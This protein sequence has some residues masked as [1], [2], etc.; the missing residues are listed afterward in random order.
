MAVRFILGRSG[1]GK[2]RWCFD[3]IV[4]SLRKSPLG[5]PILWILPRQ[6]TF[7]A[8]RWLACAGGLG[9]YFRV[10]AISFEDLG[11]E[12]LAEC[13]GAAAQ[14]VSDLGRRMILGHLLRRLQGQ[15][16]FFQQSAHQP[17]VA[18]ELD[19]T[20]DEL[21]RGGFDPD[22]IL[23]QVNSP[24]NSA[25]GAKLADLS[26]IWEAYGKFLGQDRLD[27]SRRLSE[28][29]LAIERC[30][31]LRGADVF[32]DSFYDFTAYERQVLAALGKTC[33]SVA[34]ALTLDPQSQCIGNPHLNPED[35]S[36]FYRG[37]Q[38]YRR[39][40]F[41]FKEEQVLID[42]PLM[43][44][45]Q[46]RFAQ[47]AVA[48]L[49]K[50]D[51]S[52]SPASVAAIRLIE[53]ADRAGEV[54]AAARAIADLIA[55]GLR[56]RDIAVLMRRDDD[57]RD[58]IDA[59]FRE[60]G[61][62]YFVDRRRT[63]A[64][65]PL[66]RLIRAAVLIARDNW[67]HDAVMAAIKTSLC[68]LKPLEADELENYVLLHGIRHGMW[69]SPHPWRGQGLPCDDPSAAPDAS[70]ID[71]LRRQLVGRFEPFIREITQSE[72]HPVAVLAKAIFSLLESLK[73]R[74]TINE[75]MESAAKA[76]RLE[77]RGEHERVW[78]ELVKLFD[79]MT[80]LFGDEPITLEDFRAILESA[81]EGFDLALTPPTVDQVLVG[82]VDRTRTPAI[83]AC[84]VLGLNDGQFPRSWS[85]GTIFNDADRRALIRRKIDLDPDSSRRLSD[86]D[87]LA[88]LAFTRASDRLI[89]PR[90]TADAEGRLLSSS[91]FW[92][93]V[94]ERFP[95]LLVEQAPR[96][97]DSP[98]EPIA[99]SRQ[100]VTSLM[101]W[102]RSGAPAGPWESIYQWFAARPP[103]GDAVDQVRY[104]SWKALSYKNE[105][106]LHPQTAAALF[107]SPL[108]AGVAQ[109]ES[110]RRCPYQH[111]ARY[112]LGLSARREY[113]VSGADLSRVYHDVLENLLSRVIRDKAGWN[114]LDDKK[115]RTAISQLTQ[116]LGQKLR[117]ELM[118]STARNR[119]L[120]SRIEKTLQAV[121]T[122]QKA[123]AQ[124][125]KFVPRFSNLRFGDGPYS[126]ARPADLPPL[127]VET[128]SGKQAVI[129]G[130]ID[131][132]DLL[133][134][135]AACAID[136]RLKVGALGASEVFHGL[137]LELLTCLLVLEQNGHHLGAGKLTPAAALCVQLL[138][139][140]RQEDPE[141]AIAPDDPDFPLLV[142]PRGIFDQLY[143]SAL[144]QNHDAG[145][146]S[147]V[148]M[149]LNKNGEP[150]HMKTSDVAASDEFAALLRH[151]QL[152]LGE[153]GDQILAGNIAVKPYRLDRTTPCPECAFREVCRFEPAPGSYADL[154]VLNRV[155]MLQRVAGKES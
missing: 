83:K 44:N 102:V 96:L 140:V 66:L 113:D 145:W 62:Q 12:I 111:F 10:R 36:L 87:F 60:H 134:N 119:Y 148:K 129:H 141:N 56:Y 29:L 115:L 107:T 139:W 126:S 112:G 86:E 37:E 1:A 39:L 82:P 5:P 27:P 108:H 43:L 17:G 41:A 114:A 2:S 125:G 127:V 48:L 144:D 101:R 22:A 99:T 73:A 35:G 54:N 40:L 78:D 79:E 11:Q 90:S 20:F 19:A 68:G 32:V 151:V 109:L 104:R 94:V 30:A 18:G 149:F 136:Y 75:W 91:P 3:Q 16:R 57:Y 98:P 25:L 105:A 34:I 14:Q 15:L 21:E 135:G 95:S 47:P 64:H 155:E 50:W 63:A 69:A 116:E 6:A 122:A 146:S 138:R 26:L 130:K 154:P 67:P 42:E 137:E 88:Y 53:A 89:V 7:Q 74:T 38:A 28:S 4:Q 124:R 120:L 84:I 58:L 80:S 118:I 142:Q 123:A 93:R 121:A 61:I 33:R 71:S 13:G 106:A 132:V 51:D 72:R 131:R 70:K 85:E 153:L 110:F 117:G 128:P 45:S 23:A 100:L 8:E 81:L 77:E 52:K 31:S 133:P 152:R 24:P 9:G 97:H 46:R 76:G 59:S 55:S 92:Q 103:N 150:G 147:V 49:E 143:C 65:H